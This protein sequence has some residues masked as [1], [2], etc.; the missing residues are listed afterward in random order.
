MDENA[1]WSVL[2]EA[3]EALGVRGPL[4]KPQ[5]LSGGCIH[6]AARVDAA[7]GRAL[8]VKRGDPAA[9]EG[10]AA[11]AEALAEL[12]TPGALRVP[13]PIAHGVTGGQAYLVTEYVPLTR[14]LDEPREFGAALA[15]LHATRADTFGWHR[16]NF[17]GPTPQA[18]GWL[19]DWSEF[20]R[21][22][23]LEPQLR[24]AE[25]DG[26]DRVAE[27][28]WRLCEQVDALL[29]DHSPT[30]SLLH[31]DLW[32]GNYGGD[33][34]GRPVLFDPATYYG[35]RE[36]DL[37][38]TELFGGFP[39]EFYAGYTAAW[40]LASGYET[41]KALYNLY[42]LLNHAHLF[43]GGYAGQAQRSIDRLLAGVSA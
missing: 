3:L 7:D 36:T 2:S 8:F 33:E 27:R 17:I 43:G 24:L 15:R 11:E 1:F 32:A 29:A 25:A 35:D 13:R 34:D 10:F 4:G 40:P 22:R 23:R 18:N 6:A 37:A 41:R 42:H 19:G 12:A 14:N 30:A 16:D 31:G 9:A 21:V 39:P 28:G 38:M 20:W 5:R 26:H